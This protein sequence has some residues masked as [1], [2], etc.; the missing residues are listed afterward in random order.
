M[1]HELSPVRSLFVVGVEPS[2]VPFV[3]PIVSRS[4][5]VGA[6]FVDQLA[7]RSNGTVVAGL[8]DAGL[9]DDF[10]MLRGPEFD[11]AQVDPLIR[12]FYEHTSRFTLGVIPH[13]RL[14]YKP[15]F[16][17]SGS[18]SPNASASSTFRSTHAK[19][20]KAS[21]AESIRSTSLAA[22]RSICGSG[23]VST[24]DRVCRSTLD[25]TPRCAMPD[26]AT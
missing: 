14:V 26:A 16:W 20:S 18:Y 7:S 6:G 8:D 2:Q 12:E 15:A 4:H 13:W 11:P 19:P 1:R 21:T 23:Y 3:V 22:T 17:L 9:M 24:A 10:S 25:S 5:K